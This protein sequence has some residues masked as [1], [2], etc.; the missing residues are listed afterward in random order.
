MLLVRENQKGG[1]AVD[2]WI[3]VGILVVCGVTVL[4][5]SVRREH[6]GGIVAGVFQGALGLAAVNLLSPITGVAI[7]LNGF[8]LA[9][10]GI[11]GF[12][13]VITLLLLRLL[14]GG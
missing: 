4:V 11:L 10:V 2:F 14:F 3:A 12:P 5:I 13:G 6:P 7:A 9:A 8:S 1:I